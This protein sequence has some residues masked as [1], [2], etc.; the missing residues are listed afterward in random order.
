MQLTDYQTVAAVDAT[1]ISDGT[2]VVIKRTSPLTSETVALRFLNSASLKDDP[3]N[4]CVPLLDTFPD[5]DSNMTYITQE[6]QI[7]GIAFNLII[8]RTH[9]QSDDRWKAATGSDSINLRGMQM[10][11]DDIV[12]PTSPRTVRK[13]SVSGPQ[14][15]KP[16]FVV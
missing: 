10:Q 4:H 11:D 12:S 9:N 16:D 2:K 5:N 15:Y 3:L 7:V 8:I 1:R 14:S 13:V 6:V